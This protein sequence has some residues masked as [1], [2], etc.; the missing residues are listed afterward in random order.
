MT[1]IAV[2]A[3]ALAFIL[4]FAVLTIGGIAAQGLSIEGALAIFVLALLTIGI[5]GSLRNPPRR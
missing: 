3:V 5:V 2:F 4:L 1:R